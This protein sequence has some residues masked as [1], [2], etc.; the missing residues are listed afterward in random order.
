MNK[1]ILVGPC[2][3]KSS[4]STGGAVVLFE[5]L[6]DALDNLEIDYILI[7]SN[8]N[9]YKSKFCAVYIIYKKIVAYS[10]PNN[11]LFLNSS[12]DYLFIS[13]ILPLLQYKK[14]ILRKFGGEF[15][16]SYLG[17]RGLIE[18]I[19]CRFSL[20]QYNYIYLETKA[21]VEDASKFSKIVHY[22]PNVR[23]IEKFNFKKVY[24]KKLVYIGRIYKEKGIDLI[25][26]NAQSLNELGFSINLFGPVI[27]EIYYEK[28]NQNIYVEYGGIADKNDVLNTLSR[29]DV[30]LFPSQDNGE[31]YP[32]IIIEA[33]SQ[34]LPI[35]TSS[36]GGVR[37]M[38]FDGLNGFLFDIEENEKF[39]DT[40]LK[41]TYDNFAV[42]SKYAMNSAKKYDNIS[43]TKTILKDI[44]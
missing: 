41:I 21:L 34:G 43:V 20:K 13:P 2:K 6:I 5:Q 44:L 27:D 14:S 42:L 15:I 18:K 3:N 30:L 29:Y 22:F 16:D 11:I 4:K 23:A 37:E 17:K 38:I 7:D 25:L 33:L 12:N 36:V 35:V 9:N 39:K 28:F 19:L 8:K 1:I 26:N 40:I 10:H 32:G 24:K 31:G